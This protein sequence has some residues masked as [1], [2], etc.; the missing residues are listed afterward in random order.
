MKKSITLLL[1]A[2]GFVVVNDG[3]AQRRSPNLNLGIQVAQPLGEFA[4][5]Y[6]GFP[7]GI[8][9]SF[10][11][12]VLRS[13]IEWGI[14]YAWN[15]MGS[16]D[17]DIVALINQDSINGNVYSEG[18]MAIRSTNSRYLAHARIRPLA[19]KIQPYGDVFSG[20]ETYKTTTS[21]TLDNSGYSSEL[22]TNRDHLDMTY[23]FGW[24]LGL[25][26]RVAPGVYVEGRYENI[27]GGKVKYVNDESISINN[28]NSIAFDLKESKTNKAVYQV[29]VAIG[30]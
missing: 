28:D 19:G 16:S 23:C 8:G 17:R 9:G 12:P 20:L 2:V 18:K 15:S 24:A 26:W 3:Q 21:I 4:T 14:G 1:I 22:S 11:M 27:T 25:R 5:Q 13:P 30:F 6:E 10:S 29:G 7:A